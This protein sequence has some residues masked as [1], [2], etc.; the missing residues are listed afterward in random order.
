MEKCVRGSQYLRNRP[1]K[2]NEKQWLDVAGRKPGA[3]GVQNPC[4]EW[5]SR[6]EYSTMYTARI[7]QVKWGVG[8]L[9]KYMC[10]S[11]RPEAKLR[12]VKKQ[13]GAREI[14]TENTGYFPINS[15]TNLGLFKPIVR[16]YNA[17]KFVANKC[18]WTPCSRV[19][20]GSGNTSAHFGRVTIWGK[21]LNV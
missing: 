12:W 3:S 1:R 13:S 15:L 2:V 18:Y 17:Q 14:E 11:S 6:E 7:S 16:R 5:V 10:W 8:V 4:E 19:W 9:I 21:H 20:D